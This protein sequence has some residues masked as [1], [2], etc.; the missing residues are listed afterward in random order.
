MGADTR[1]PLASLYRCMPQLRETAEMKSK[2]VHF[3]NGYP[4]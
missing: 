3:W 2:N 4:M 1:N